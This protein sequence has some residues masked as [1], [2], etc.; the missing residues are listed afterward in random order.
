MGTCKYC[1]K[2]PGWFSHSHKE[3]E[4]KHTKGVNEFEA[5]VSSYFTQRATASDVQQTRNRLTT[6][7]FLNE[8]DICGVA[9]SEIRQYTASIHRP[10]SPSSM[11]LMD[12]FLNAVG[13]S[14]SKINKQGAVD[15][16]TKKLLKGFMVEYFTDQLTLQKAHS[17]CEK[18]LGRFPMPPSNIEDAYL[19]VL[20]KAA[21]NLM[22]NGSISDD[23]Q[24]KMDDYVNYLHL[25]VNN[26]PVKYQN[27]EISKIGQMSIIKSLQRGVVPASS[28][29][30]PIMLGKGETIIWTYNGVTMYQEKIEKEYGGRRT[31][32][33]FRVMRGATYHV[34]GTKIK[35]VEHSYMDNKGVG[36][37][38][39]TNKHIIFQGDTAALRIPYFKMIGVTPYNDGIEIHRDGANMKRLTFQG[40]DSWF[41]TSILPYMV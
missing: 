9:D 32:W 26:L 24:M 12:D 5:I 33:S 10:F 21:T 15:E 41:L 18:V 34:G 25:P 6:D 14:Y 8:E 37:L 1:G 4:E 28:T 17:R 2:D 23:D 39:I 30:A 40:F 31:G 16:F 11:R 7:S 22:K 35:P 13:V 20:N 27:S 38:Y 29:P 3:C 19:Y 36:T